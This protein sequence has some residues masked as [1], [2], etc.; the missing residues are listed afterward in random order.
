MHEVDDTAHVTMNLDITTSAWL[1][2][3][4]QDLIE[5]YQRSVKE[6][7]NDWFQDNLYLTYSRISVPFC[8]CYTWICQLDLSILYLIA[9]CGRCH[10]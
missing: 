3:F 5:K 6:M 2:D 9:S 1:I 10:A 4:I 8:C 7:V